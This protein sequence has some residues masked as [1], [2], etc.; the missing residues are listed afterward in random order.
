MKLK[1]LTALWVSMIVFV[2]GSAPVALA[3]EAMLLSKIQDLQRQMID[4]KVDMQKT[5]DKQN[6]KIRSLEKREPTIK[7]AEPAGDFKENLKASIGNAD[8]WLKG[9]KFKGDARLRYEARD[10]VDS[11]AARDQ[12]RFRYRLR[13]GFEKEFSPEMKVGFRLASAPGDSAASARTSSNETFDSQFDFKDIAIDRAYATYKPEW[14]KVGPVKGLEITAGKFDN[15]FD[16]GS[17]WIVWD[18]DVTPEGLYEKLDLNLL[19]SDDLDI[20]FTSIAGQ[21]ILEEGTA[22]ASHDDAELFAWQNGLNFKFKGITEE[23]INTK[24][25]FTYY[26]YKDFANP[27]NFG[28]AGNNPVLGTG[29]LAAGDFDIIEI[30]NEV[31]FQIIPNLP[32]S[33]L[34]FDWLV[35]T[36]ETAP[37]DATL[38]DKD[39]AWALGLKMGKAKKKGTWEASYTYAQ[40]EGNSV[41]SVFTDSDF[42]GTDERG[43][44]IGLKYAL[45]DYLTL[46]T[47]AFFTNNISADAIA[48]D[49]ERRLFQVDLAWKF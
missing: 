46:G 38:N 34:F 27:G 49:A 15:P 22:A 28:A 20:G 6:K 21:L 31:S 44:V 16:Y 19:K 45:T 1:P 35:N 9:L 29:A 17:T 48:A 13:F 40:I 2:M 25:V 24:H 36:G 11:A 39:K 3:D 43:S 7:L 4:M 26:D 5:I 33:K 8:K 18:S 42:G 47:K 23:P 14:A 10:L 41:P 32:K 12:N 30:Y 37:T